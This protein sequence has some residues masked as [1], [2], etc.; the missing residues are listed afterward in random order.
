M[1]ERI[2][3]KEERRGGGEGVPGTFFLIGVHYSLLI[4]SLPISILNYVLRIR[5][6]SEGTLGKFERERKEKDL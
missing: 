3:V 1:G 4:Q 2:K 5:V 6:L